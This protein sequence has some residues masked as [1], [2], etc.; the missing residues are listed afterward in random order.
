MPAIFA[1]HIQELLLACCQTLPFVLTGLSPS[2]AR[3]SSRPQ[4]A[5]WRATQHLHLPSLSGGIQFALC[6]VPSPVLTACLLVSLPADTKTFQFSAFAILTD[7]KVRSHSGIPGSTPACGSPELSA[8]CH[9]L[10]RRGEPSHPPI[11]IFFRITQKLLLR[12]FLF[13]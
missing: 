12:S 4:D 11:T 3:R 9:T 1:A 8:A 10:P 13:L 7:S 2:V 6:R 5:R